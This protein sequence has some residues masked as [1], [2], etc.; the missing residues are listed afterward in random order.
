[1]SA[2]FTPELTLQGLAPRLAALNDELRQWLRTEPLCLKPG[3]KDDLRGHAADLE[4]GAKELA[5]QKPMLVILLMGGTGVGKSSLLNALAGGKVALASFT[6]PTTREPVV[7][8]HR[9]VPV[10]RLPPELR[11]CRLVAHD[12]K[13]LLQKVLVDTPDLDSNE[14]Q[15]RDALEAV[16]PV[17][18]VVLYVGSQEK[19]HDQAGWEMFLR[20]KQ[21]RAFAFV[22]NKWDRCLHGLNSGLRPDE[23][24][25]RD[26]RENGFSQPLLFRTC[27]QAWVDSGGKPPADLPAGEQFPELIRW[28]ELGLNRLEI[29]AIKTRGIGQLLADLVRTLG[30][31]KPPLLTEAAAA[32]V[33][34]W[35][36][37]LAE[38]ADSC[39]DLLLATIDPYQHDVEK[40]FAWHTHQ[41]FRGLMALLL[42]ASS[43]LRYWSGP[44]GGLRGNLLAAAASDPGR[45]GAWDLAGFSQA[46]LN[47]AGDR[48]LD[49]R[50]QS[51]PNRLVVLG[52]QA[53]LPAE[54][55]GAK[56]EAAGK[57]DWRGHLAQQFVEIVTQAEGEL[58]RPTGPRRWLLDA[59]V[60]TAEFL[61]LALLLLTSAWLLH[62]WFWKVP[63]RDFAFSDLLLPLCAVLIGMLVLFVIIQVAL[64][65]RWT[66]IRGTLAKKLRLRVR[67]DLHQVFLPLP[68]Q[69][70]DAL[71]QERSK[72]ESLEAVAR[73]LADWVKRH[74][75]P[76]PV[77]AL[78]ESPSGR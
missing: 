66:T 71:A 8:H 20:Q 19:Y 21:R 55:L 70:V 76:T 35:E 30:Q 14:P 32:T 68:G 56:V 39:S 43:R 44:W 1:M 9:E 65:V 31:A 49:A 51:L 36:K 45:A 26:L 40:H 47:L 23:D 24:L 27:A 74:E 12:R 18:D 53:G 78:F 2:A 5:E 62:D 15:N 58:T 69:L 61:P 10:D 29:E 50:I 59:L 60:R 17:A 46:C 52:D 13:E 41:H 4:R 6:R 16:L 73:H 37:F 42:G 33:H 63:R 75:N 22:L 67:A 25:L 3:H 77:A 34:S 38:E 57:R 64:P 28:L 48:Y 11:Q 7:Y 54:P 72:I